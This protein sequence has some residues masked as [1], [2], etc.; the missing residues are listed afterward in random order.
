MREYLESNGIKVVGSEVIQYGDKEFAVKKQD[1]T[2]D[3]M[4]VLVDFAHGKPMFVIHTDHHDTQTGVEKDTSVSFKPSRS[5]VATISQVVSPKEIF[6][7]D[8]ITLISTVDSADFAKYGLKPKDIMN[9]IFK[10]DKDKSLQSNKFALG[11][12]ANKLLL[13]YKNKPG[14]LE[15]LVMN[16]SPSLL[17]ILQNTKRIA[18]EKNYATPEMMSSNQKNYIQSQQNSSRVQFEDGIIVQ[19]GGGALSKPGAYDRYVPFEN[20]PDADFLVIA[21][22]MGLVQA[23]CNPFNKERQLKGVNLGEIADEVMLKWKGQLEDKIIPLSTIKWV[24]ETSAKEGS[25]GFTDADLEAFYGDKV[26][27]IEN[28]EQYLSSIKKIMAKPSKDLKDEEWSVLDRFGVPAWD[29]IE[30]NSGGHKCITNISALN[31]FGRAKR[32][33]QDPYRYNPEADDAPYVKFVKMIQREF[34][35]KLKEKINDQ[36]GNITENVDVKKYYVDRSNIQGRGSFAKNDLEENEVIGLLHTINKPN[37]SYDFTDLGKMHNHSDNPNCHNVLKKKQRFLVASR[38]IKKGEELTTNYRLQ[39]DLEQPEHFRVNKSNKEREMLPHIDGYRSYSPFQDLEY[40]I[41]NGN[42]IDCD[43]IVHDL[44]LVGD[45]GVIKYGPKNSGAHYLDDAKKVVEL[46]L[47]DNEDPTELFSSESNMMNWLN[48][49]LD[50]VDVN[51]EI[52]RNFFN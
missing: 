21:W 10:L 35:N 45:N 18:Q 2:G 3:T 14:F 28:G 38:P 48:K 33:N 27:E 46:P 8:D 43:D 22:P 49:K 7:Q 6:T 23:S 19:Y 51:F 11:L 17:N 47:R 29:M 30:A 50:K 44:I 34:V 9:F 42:G 52:R 36:S 26:R 32:P 25:V 41:V 4:P 39:P 40:I 20:Y 5:N 1:A 12:A 24:S 16:A 37:V 15:E 13:A 31:Y